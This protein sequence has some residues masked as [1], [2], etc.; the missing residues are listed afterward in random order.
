ML[1]KGPQIF[2]G[3]CLVIGGIL[4]FL[5][6]NDTLPEREVPAEVAAGH[7]IW[8]QYNCAGCHTLHGQ[9][10]AYGPDLTT[11]Y[12]QRGETY[13]RE[14]F[15]NPNAFHPDARPMPRFA[16]TVAETDALIAFLA[17]A[18]MSEYAESWP[19]RMIAVSGLSGI[20]TT[21]LVDINE[22]ADAPESAAIQRG[23][24]TFTRQCAS[25][26]SLTPD[27]GGLPG[28][29][30]FG[31]A[32]R[33]WY[34]VIGQSAEQYIRISILDPSD[35]I[36]EGYADVMPKNFGEILTSDEINDLVTFLLTLGDPDANDYDFGGARGGE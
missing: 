32:D 17:D 19:P 24:I 2:F 3:L 9:G 8:R 13:L 29:S 10:G 18:A 31:I 7:E 12:T 21:S 30:L 22:A 35:Y 16:L 5:I 28:P 27:S 34:R 6:I 15:V 1:M 4:G 36:V 14:F 20:G 23:S 11:N 26:H 33:A 25:C